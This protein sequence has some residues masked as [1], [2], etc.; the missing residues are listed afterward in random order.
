EPPAPD[1]EPV[2][3]PD[4]ADEPE[5]AGP[6]DSPEPAAGV[7]PAPPE[8][9]V[10]TPL[11]VAKPLEPEDAPIPDAEDVAA[12]P[13][14]PAEPAWRPRPASPFRGVRQ[15][16]PSRRL[17]DRRRPGRPPLRRSGGRVGAIPRTL[18][19]RAPP[20]AVFRWGVRNTSKRGVFRTPYATSP[21]SA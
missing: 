2:E 7:E 11:A 5:P 18:H 9:A 6:C 1:S 3:V 21:G 8:P 17:P 16:I 20:A 13:I 15:P 14:G 10:P 4:V 12:E 19:S